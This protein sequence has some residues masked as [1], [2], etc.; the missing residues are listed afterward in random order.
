MSVPNRSSESVAS[1]RA[2]GPISRTVGK[3]R[4]SWPSLLRQLA[5]RASASKIP[6]ARIV[7]HGVAS[8]AG[9]DAEER[10]ASPTSGPVQRVRNPSR[11]CCFEPISRDRQ[12]T[13]RPVSTSSNARCDGSCR[14]PG[15]DATRRAEYPSPSTK[16]RKKWDGR[17]DARSYERAIGLAAILA[18]RRRR[19]HRSHRHMEW[20]T[21]GPRSAPQRP[22]TRPEVEALGPRRQ[23]VPGGNSPKVV[24]R[25]AA[26]GSSPAR[27]LV[28]PRPLVAKPATGRVS[29]LSDTRRL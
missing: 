8:A 22:L 21:R 24:D 17:S 28:E 13:A 7:R 2:R 6:S 27:P 3:C 11:F 12:E 18:E 25:N 5:T 19:P 23:R 4:T 9:E 14:V 16:S 26:A 15:V 29:M 1:C 10:P 20:P